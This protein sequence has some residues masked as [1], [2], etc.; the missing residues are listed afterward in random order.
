VESNNY[1]PTR[2]EERA[3][4]R[5]VEVGGRGGRPGSFLYPDGKVDG[6]DACGYLG[7]SA[8]RPR[9]TQV[10]T[11]VTVMP[12]RTAAMTARGLRSSSPSQYL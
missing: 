12:D 1:F 6:P 11:V 7:E 9:T 8:V 5:A 3:G 4:F 10:R 2:K